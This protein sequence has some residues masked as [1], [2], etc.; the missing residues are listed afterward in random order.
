MQNDDL[1]DVLVTKGWEFVENKNDRFKWAFDR[2]ENGANAWLHKTKMWDEKWGIQYIFCNT[3]NI[4]KIKSELIELGFRKKNSEAYSNLIFSEYT[5]ENYL[6]SINYES[7]SHEYECNSYTIFLEKR[8]SLK[9][10]LLEEKQLRDEELENKKIQETCEKNRI[11]RKRRTEFFS[12]KIDSTNQF[13][14]N[15]PTNNQVEIEN[16]YEFPDTI[17]ADS[18]VAVFEPMQKVGYSKIQTL[19][20]E[21][22]NDLS[23]AKSGLY[24]NEK[25]IIVDTISNYYLIEYDRCDYDNYNEYSG[26]V[27][28]KFISLTMLSNHNR[29]KKSR[30]KNQ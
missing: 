6:I 30:K 15:I 7:K 18:I 4:G 24:K 19:I 2:S 29:R 21:F 17:V 12:N 20:F 13:I 16:N 14:E 28:K 5:N 23:K 10:R 22:P 26:Y 1:N 8:K 11:K 3:K 9:Q 25:I 27:A